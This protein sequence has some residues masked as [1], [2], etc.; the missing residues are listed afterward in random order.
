[1]TLPRLQK[2]T[3][4]EDDQIKDINLSLD[5]IEQ[6][7]ISVQYGTAVPTLLDYGVLYIRDTG[8]EQAV[9]IKTGKGTIIAI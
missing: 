2:L 5:Q 4:F 1:M 6:H 7:A 9:Y 3:K 8:S